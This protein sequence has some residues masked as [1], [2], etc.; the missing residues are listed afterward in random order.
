MEE[1]ITVR[2]YKVTTAKNSGRAAVFKL[3]HIK[4]RPLNMALGREIK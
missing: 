4:L 1:R 3:P 2:H